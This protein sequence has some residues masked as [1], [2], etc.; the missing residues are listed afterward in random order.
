MA[1]KDETIS[2]ALWI[3]GEERVYPSLRHLFLVMDVEIVDSSCI[4]ASAFLNMN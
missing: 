1:R 2:V 3:G 4:V